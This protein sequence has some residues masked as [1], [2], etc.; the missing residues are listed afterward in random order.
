MIYKLDKVI[1]I[2]TLVIIV[3]SLIALY[4]SCHQ[5][6][7]FVKKNIF[8]KQL[9]WICIGIGLM[10]LFSN[11]DY[12]KFWDFT[13]PFY[14]FILFTLILVLALGRTRLGAQRWLELGLLN[15][16]PSE[17]AKLAVV[18]LLARYFSQRSV[19]KLNI[20]RT[21]ILWLDTF[22]F[23]FLFVLIP[24]FFVLI[25]PDLG[26]ALMF[27][28]IFLVMSYFVGVKNKYILSFLVLSLLSSPI[29]WHI[30]RPYQK[31]RLL[32]FLNPNR[33][34]LGAGY[35]IIQ[36]KIAI[37]SGRILGKGWLAGTQNQLNF[38]T[39]R[40][41][42]FIFSTIGE[43]WGLLGG[44]FLIFLFF[45]LT[46][47]VLKISKLVNDPFAKNLCIGIASLFTIQFF[48]NFAM[49]I[50]IMPVVGLPLPLLSY[51]GSSLVSF[52]V[53]IGIIL[54]ISRNT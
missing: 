53:S 14:L 44:V 43:E 48:I 25:Q 39:E 4:S 15:F 5:S 18:L 8:F 23:P 52:L 27:V 29:F 6:N 12:R 42:D 16:Q 33:D 28:F 47:R 3:F 54:N 35:T 11:I 37:G 26:T 1:L 38:L 7:I 40:H 49:T 2:I 19:G 10:F 30:L 45:V 13:W 41:T 9:F 22:L 34:P 36:S 50:G 21:N 51:G 17:F 46:Y 31:D 32:V 24:L 20:S